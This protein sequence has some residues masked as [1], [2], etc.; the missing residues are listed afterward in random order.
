MTLSNNAS[1]LLLVRTRGNARGP[2]P[3]RARAIRAGRQRNDKAYSPFVRPR[4]ASGVRPASASPAF[5]CGRCLVLPSASAASDTHTAGARTA[6]R[7]ETKDT[8]S[9]AHLLRVLLGGESSSS[10]SYVFVEET[11]QKRFKQTGFSS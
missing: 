2:S 5:P 9:L 6:E 4:S 10:V 1:A 3:P 7:R 11:E 8:R